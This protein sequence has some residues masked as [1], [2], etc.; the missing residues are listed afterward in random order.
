MM[1]TESVFGESADAEAGL[2]MRGLLLWPSLSLKCM[3]LVWKLDKAE[4]LGLSEVN[5]Q[6]FLVPLKCSYYV[7]T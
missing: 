1:G 4:L 5:W 3:A 7:I 2:R 6:V